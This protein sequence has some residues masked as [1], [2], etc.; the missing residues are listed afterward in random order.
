MQPSNT[1]PYRLANVRAAIGH[2][3]LGRGAS[4]IAGLATAIVL[5]RHMSVP[6]YAGYIA[7]MGI[8]GIIT[9]LASLG[10]DRAVTRYVPEGRLFHEPGR[11][12]GFV[13]RMLGARLL[14]AGLL[15]TILSAIWPWAMRLFDY[16][17]LASMP[18]AA[19]IYLIASA[20]SQLLATVLQALVRQKLLTQ[21]N[22]VQW[23]GRL[24]WIGIIAYQG[25]ELGLEQVL[26]IMAVPELIGA[27]ILSYAVHAAIRPT[28][29]V[30]ETK[31]IDWP[32]WSDVRQ[33]A[34]HSYA[35]NILAS[36]PQGYFMRTLVAATLPVE[37]V[38]AYG[39]F[40]NLIDRLR[41]Y[42]P[43]QLMYNLVEPV[44]VARYLESKDTASLVRNAQLMYKANLLILAGGIVFLAIGGPE[45]VGLL[46]KGKYAELSWIL[47]LLL[48]QTI[49]GS[50]VLAMQ[51]VANTLKITHLLSQAGMLALITMLVFMAGAYL[52]GQPLGMLFGPLVYSMA[53]NAILVA[54]INRKYIAYRPPLRESARLVA[55]GALTV[56]AAIMLLGGLTIHGNVAVIAIAALGGGVFIAFS[57]RLGFVG[58]REKELIAQLCRSKAAATNA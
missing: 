32:D 43:I 24:A 56:L 34:G 27:L 12:A 57:L 23:G 17:S 1:T 40:S 8:V 28:K 45:L 4:A 31:A 52:A 41:M 48:F 36:L 30:Q 46:T 37:I 21:I 7:V 54:L 11:L 55:V 33:T 53:M 19:L 50:H 58:A 39:F 49:S 15:A 16:V 29:P 5:V 35:F 20:A 13:W 2:Y 10:L 9:M 44:L 18:L 38:A 25:G 47:G 22:V 26:W 51:L 42:L 3:L 14:M 6:A